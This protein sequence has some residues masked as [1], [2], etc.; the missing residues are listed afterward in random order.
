MLGASF[1]LHLGLHLLVQLGAAIVIEEP[2]RQQGVEAG[3]QVA[4]AR[5]RRA[6]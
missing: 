1:P 2:A 6:A 4:A 5:R 3:R